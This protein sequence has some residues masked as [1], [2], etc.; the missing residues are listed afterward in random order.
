MYTSTANECLSFTLEIRLTSLG[1]HHLLLKQELEDVSIHQLNQAMR[2][3]MPEMGIEEVIFGSDEEDFWGM[4]NLAEKLIDKL[5]AHLEP[6][7]RWYE[8]QQDQKRHHHHHHHK[9]RPENEQSK[10][11]HESPEKHSEKSLKTDG[12]SGLKRPPGEAPPCESPRDPYS[13]TNFLAR[14]WVLSSTATDLPPEML[15]SGVRGSAL[16]V[17]PV[18]QAAAVLEEW[19]RYD[20][21]DVHD[22]NSIP[23]FRVPRELCLYG[24]PTPPSDYYVGPGVS[25]Q[26]TRRDRRVRGMVAILLESWVSEIRRHANHHELRDDG[27]PSAI[28]DRQ[29][30]LREAL[31]E[32]HDGYCKDSVERFVPYGSAP[33]VTRSAV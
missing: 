29:L 19:C 9:K 11:P 30:E 3:A 15:W 33:G 14:T 25:H 28:S 6:R 27:S 4:A 18:R 32:C 26:G 24:R 17:Q 16:L 8:S 12:T 10:P 20:L 31:D 22:V 1:N 5:V 23:T 13:T 7:I 21:P 2:R